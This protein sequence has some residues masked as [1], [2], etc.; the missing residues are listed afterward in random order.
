M[1]KLEQFRINGLAKNFHSLLKTNNCVNQTPSFRV[2]N[3]RQQQFLKTG[4]IDTFLFFL[5]VVLHFTLKD[6]QA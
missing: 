4:N 6:V 1:I 3:I 5:I 2:A